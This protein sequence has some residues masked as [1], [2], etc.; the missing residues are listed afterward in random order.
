MAEQSNKAIYI[1]AHCG[2]E[3]A[4]ERRYCTQCTNRDGRDKVD[5]ENKKVGEEIERKR[6]LGILP[7]DLKQPEQQNQQG[8]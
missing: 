3:A 7:W 8:A 4:K 6:A 1:C 2:E 5:A